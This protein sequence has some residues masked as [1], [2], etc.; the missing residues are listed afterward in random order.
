MTAR[1]LGRVVLVTGGASGLGE[2]VVERLAAEGDRVIVADLD[3]RRAQQVAD[4]LVAT[5]RESDS[6]T[7]DVTSE[8]EVAAMIDA[9][10]ER[11]GR[12]DVLVCSTGLETQ[13][14]MVDTT[15]EEWHHA[16]DAN[17]TGPFL[18]LKYAIP[19]MAKGGGG[20]VVLI[21]SVGAAGT[22]GHA[23]SRVSKAA[24]VDLAT[25]A[26][27]EHAS[28]GVRVNVVSPSGDDDATVVAGVREAVRFLSS[29][30]AAAITGAVLPVVANPAAPTG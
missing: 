21:G 15:D 27:A 8:G 5:G 20:A 7:V 9:V 6:M 12:L 13:A 1:V 26:A 28:D 18:C 14:P 3:E 29:R 22:P 16:L 19:A 2:A 4:N 10:V 25:Q 30:A 11:H 24:L 17:L 23:A